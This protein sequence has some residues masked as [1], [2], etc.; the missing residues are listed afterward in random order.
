[1]A[2]NAVPFRF[3]AVL[4]VLSVTPSVAGAAGGDAVQVPSPAKLVDVRVNANIC[5]V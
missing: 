3:R 4:R 2:S 1:V 5:V